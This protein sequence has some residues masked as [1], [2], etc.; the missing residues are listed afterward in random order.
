M[1][2]CGNEC[3]MKFLL[4]RELA[5]ERRGGQT[6][7]S[8]VCPGWL[9]GIQVSLEPGGGI[10]WPNGFECCPNFLYALITT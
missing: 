6:S 4:L 7:A 10:A 8:A 3:K 2:G 9:M 1:K 5:N